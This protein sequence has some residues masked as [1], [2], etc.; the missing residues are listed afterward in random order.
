M[1][2]SK[3]LGKLATRLKTKDYRSTLEIVRG[4]LKLPSSTSISE[5]EALLI[6]TINNH[7]GNRVNTDTTLMALSLLTGTFDNRNTR[8]EPKEEKE[9]L[10]GSMV[11]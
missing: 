4:D 6:Y 8:V 5:L 2:T 7:Y 1:E 3:Y 9:Y 11:K 10:R